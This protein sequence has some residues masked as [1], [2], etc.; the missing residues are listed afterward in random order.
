MILCIIVMH[1]H[2]VQ[3]EIERT[4]MRVD[5]LAFFRTHERRR[6]DALRVR[7]LRSRARD[8]RHLAPQRPG[9]LHR[10][11]PEST[12]PD[13]AHPR[14]TRRPVP[15]HR[16]VHRHSRA[17][18]R[19]GEPR[20]E[21]ARNRHREP[22]V[23]DVSR[24]VPTLGLFPDRMRPRASK[25]ILRPVRSDH[26]LGAHLF[27]AGCALGARETAVD[28]APDAHRVADGKSRHLGSDRRARPG[29]LVSRTIRILRFRH[30][31]G[32]VSRGVHDVAVTD[33]AVAQ[34]DENVARTEW[35]T[36][37]ATRDEAARRVVARDAQ[38]WN[39]F[40]RGRGHRERRDV[41]RVAVCGAVREFA[42][43]SR[44]VSKDANDA[45][46]DATRRETRRGEGRFGRINFFPR[47]S[48]RLSS[49]SRVA[50]SL[51]RA[52]EPNEPNRRSMDGF[53]PV[54]EI[55][56]VVARSTRRRRESGA[57]AHGSRSALRLHDVSRAP[58]VRG[59]ASRRGRVSRVAN[60]AT[61]PGRA[62]RRSDDDD[63][64]V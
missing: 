30:H 13:D 45:V 58:R 49:P 48:A 42:N 21:P 4:S 6:A 56:R 12:Q 25:L 29:E 41:R 11:L 28:D 54:R 46:F 7:L 43:A 23:D 40:V 47:D 34:F 55:S 31:P 57:F 62:S 27:F 15:P 53:L 10:H 8:H 50:S 44:L 9:D 14:P 22:F 18:H 2:R 16:I 17:H 52:N 63:R 39:R 3:D 26:A 5:A 61:L 59:V 37:R 51:E 35:T 24:G 36:M 1:G 20:V 60:A 19:T 32:H 33:A 38:E 64:S